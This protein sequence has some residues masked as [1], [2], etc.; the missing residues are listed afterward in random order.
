MRLQ[1]YLLNYL[2]GE[3]RSGRGVGYAWQD[4]LVGR[5]YEV[6]A[7]AKKFAVS[8]IPSEVM[9]AVGQPMGAL[10][11]WAMLALTHHFLVGVSARKAGYPMGTFSA[12]AV[13]GDDI[14]IADGRVAR[15]YLLLM[16]ELGVEIGL[17]KSLVSRNG[18]LEFA[19]RYFVRGEDCSPV[20]LMEVGVAFFSG[21]ACLE[22]ARKYAVKFSRMVSVLG[23]GFRVKARLAVLQSLPKRLR[24]LAVAWYGPGG[25]SPVPL[26]AWC[27]MRSALEPLILNCA[28]A[29][30][31]FEA[32]CVSIL[33]TVERRIKKFVKG[34][35][36]FTLKDVPKPTWQCNPP[37]L[38]EST[39]DGKVWRVLSMERKILHVCES[40][41][42]CR[43]W[44]NTHLPEVKPDAYDDRN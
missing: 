30:P 40:R 29:L 37:Y 2:L 19:K 22:F 13:L 1:A 6:P 44:V 16:R 20:P 43:K 18:V 34:T 10:S 31:S 36:G 39:P 11:S 17:A 35:T 12:Y 9:Y 23:Y 32:Y 21:S 7:T 41:P 33:E 38:I 8:A 15:Q 14:V 42:L 24:G 25:V 26:D 5:S 4:V 3:T 28:K 27:Q